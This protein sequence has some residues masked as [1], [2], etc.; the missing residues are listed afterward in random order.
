MTLEIFFNSLEQCSNTRE[1]STHVLLC[2]AGSLAWAGDRAGLAGLMG[3]T[4]SDPNL[5][6]LTRVRSKSKCIEPGVTQ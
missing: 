6:T 1:F 3:Q 5:N 4:G 2:P